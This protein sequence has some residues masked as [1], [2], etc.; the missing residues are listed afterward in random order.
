MSSTSR[1]QNVSATDINDHSPQF[2]RPVYLVPLPENNHIGAEVLTVRATDRDEGAGGQ[3]TYSLEGDGV[4]TWLEI[5]ATSGVVTA[6]VPLDRETV[7]RL[8]FV[9]VARDA[10]EPRR[11]G[12]A[13]VS[14]FVIDVNDE[15]PAFSTTSYE[16]QLTDNATAAGSIVGQVTAVDR[17]LGSNGQVMSDFFL[18]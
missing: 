8:N 16:F 6:R 10:G 3:L 9:V 17:D 4:S 14:V 15:R 13:S 2:V 12:T 5:G 11:S 1:L 7:D 18:L